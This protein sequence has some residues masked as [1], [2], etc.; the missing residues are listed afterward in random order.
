MAEIATARGYQCIVVIPDNQ[1][2][3]KKDLLRYAGATLVEIPKLPYTNPNNYIRLGRR[4][5]KHLGAV[6]TNQFDNVANRRA[7]I[8]STGPEIWAQ[9]NGKID[10]FSCAAGTGGTL[11][12]TA[13]YLRSMNESIKIGITDPRGAKLVRYFRDGAFESVGESISEGIGQERITANLEGFRPDYM[14]ELHDNEVSIY[15]QLQKNK[16]QTVK[17][18]ELTLLFLFMLLGFILFI[19]ANAGRRIISWNIIWNQCSRIN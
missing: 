2:Q 19:Q 8:E 9:L 12:G 18:L 10:G 3:D 11:A 14:F 16:I 15:F 13:Q 1:S 17:F 5:A 7:H 6:Y 4:I